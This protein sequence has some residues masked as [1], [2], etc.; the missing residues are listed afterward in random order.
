MLE[1]LEEYVEVWVQLFEACVAVV[2]YAL[3]ARR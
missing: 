1:L 3:G 2:R